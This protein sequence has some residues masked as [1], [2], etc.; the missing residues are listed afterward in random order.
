MGRQWQPGQSGNPAGRPPKSRALTAILEAAGNKT[1]Q[2]ADKRVARKRLLA[3]MLWEI[4]T[5]GKTTLP[6]GRTLILEP[7][8]WL[9]LVKFI[10]SHIDGPPKQEVDVTS[11]GEV[12][13]ITVI[14]VVKER[15]E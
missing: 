14:E 3:R 13:P 15:G 4:S 6:D 7:A 9:T 8:E 2:D 12:L 10:Y 5:S 11:A 1:V